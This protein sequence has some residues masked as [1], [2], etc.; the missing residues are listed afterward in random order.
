MD[1][2]VFLLCMC[3]SVVQRMDDVTEGME[4]YEGKIVAVETDLKRLGEFSPQL[5]KVL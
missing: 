2:L 3:I 5:K 1:S 4:N